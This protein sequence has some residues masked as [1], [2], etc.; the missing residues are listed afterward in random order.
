VFFLSAGLRTTWDLGGAAVFVVAFALLAAA[1]VGK[2]LGVRIAGR[3]LGWP[4]GEAAIVGWLLQT[5]ALIM[6][7]FVNVLLD[8]GLISSG[9]FTALLLMAVASTMITV[10]VVAPLLRRSR[11]VI[12]K[13]A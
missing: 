12:F 9:M 4:R 8:R 1:V 3:V 5:K 13:A 7:I 2:L 10:P 6:I 11:E